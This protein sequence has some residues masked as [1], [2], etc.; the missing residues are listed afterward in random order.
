[1][2]EETTFASEI[3]PSHFREFCDSVIFNEKGTYKR[4]RVKIKNYI[5]HY[6]VSAEYV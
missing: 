5:P 4:V 2:N 6:D 3:V 1:M